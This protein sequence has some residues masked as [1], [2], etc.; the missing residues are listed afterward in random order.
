MK[1]KVFRLLAAVVIASVT[2][3]GV[4]FTSFYYKSI[5]EGMRS[6]LLK[7]AGNMGYTINFARIEALRGETADA[8]SAV[9]ARL[10]KQL[11]TSRGLYPEIRFVYLL[12]MK[13][14]GEIFFYADSEEQ[15]SPA[16]SPPG[17]V[18]G[19]AEQ[20]V[21][22]IFSDG[23]AVVTG[24]T[25]D[26]WGTFMTALIPLYSRYQG[27]IGAVL[28]MD[29]EI[30]EWR[31]IVIMKVLPAVLFFLF[32]FVFSC[33]VFIMIEIK[34][35][36][37]RVIVTA[38]GVFCVVCVVFFAV[39]ND[40][41][42]K[43]MNAEILSELLSAQFRTK[44]A[45]LKQTRDIKLDALKGFFTNSDHVSEKEFRDFVSFIKGGPAVIM[46]FWAE[47]CGK[48]G[49]TVN[50]KAGFS[51]YVSDQKIE[52]AIIRREIV[53][54]IDET[55]RTGLPVI[56]APFETNA[57]IVW[58][59][60]GRNQ[61][62]ILGG[63]I[64]FGLFLSLTDDASDKRIPGRV[65]LFD[66]TDGGR[67]PIGGLKEGEKGI[68]EGGKQSIF[69]KRASEFYS[70]MFFLGRI[71][72]VYIHSE[73]KMP[74]SGALWKTLLAGAAV[75]III[76]AFLNRTLLRNQEL[77]SK[78]E[79][80]AKQLRENEM[81]AFSTLQS[82][83]DGVINLDARGRIRALNKAAFGITGCVSKDTIGKEIREIDFFV[84]DGSDKEFY[85]GFFEGE[86]IYFFTNMRL[87]TA[88]KGQRFIEG[89][90]SPV[91]D[92][93]E[94][95]TGFI[96]AF[97]DITDRV[98]SEKEKELHRER[99]QS[100]VSILSGTQETVQGFLDFALNEAVK[101]TASKMGYIYFYDEVKKEFELNSWSN[102]VMKE[103]E[104]T[105]AH[106]KYHLDKA[107]VWGDAVR[108]RKTIIVNDFEAPDPRKKGYPKGHIHL[109]RFMTIP[110]F[111]GSRIVAVVGVADKE[112]PYDE[113]DVLQLKL[114]MKTV[115]EITCR[116]KAE[117]ELKTSLEKIA[118]I[119]S[120]API[121]MG[122]VVDRVF[123]EVN[124]H[125]GE[126]TGYGREEL[127]GKRARI[128]YPDDE[129]FKKVGEVKYRMMRESG[130]GSVET[131]WKRKDGKVID[132]FL[133]SAWANPED[134]SKGA[135]FTALDITDRAAAEKR[136]R[137]LVE[138][139]QKID[140]MKS[141]FIS[142]VSHELR[143]PLTSIKG[144][145]SLLLRGA[146]GGLNDK[147]MDFLNAVSVNSDRLLKLINDILDISK[148][149]S[150]SFE[151]T[152][153]ACDSS[154]IVGDAVREAAVLADKKSIML[155]DDSVSGVAVYA[156]RF[157]ISQVLVNLITNSI[158]FSPE[159]TAVYI[160]A[161]GVSFDEIKNRVKKAGVAAASG[162]YVMFS[163]KDN[164]RGIDGRNMSRIFERFFQIMEGD[165]KVYKGVGLGLHICKMIVEKH[166]GHIWAES[167]GTGKGA[168]VIF[169][170]PESS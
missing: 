94:R 18:Y 67:V 52:N 136:L 69:N 22:D 131:N 31:K 83:A 13:P 155:V 65:R 112:S 135:V 75:C 162:R 99:L 91:R 113:T 9:Y 149:E 146:A 42:E 170:L 29:V 145:I 159:K 89:S 6:E 71:Y 163:V 134:T 98:E 30:G 133:S 168:E 59:H 1:K 39:Y 63:L 44:T 109:R 123:T 60:E 152:K 49:Y 82:I 125:M 11:I 37:R 62:G 81:Q 80:S 68:F 48:N 102:E 85:T 160:S 150:G 74:Y 148:M 105:E 24:P 151:I 19:E 165:S 27:G 169:I 4:L 154:A 28:G 158:K 58:K 15:G 76:I 141:N 43:R 107:G 161:A 157:R 111:E 72:K 104:V 153:E 33:V 54:A 16:E 2:L 84:L 103:C 147:Q 10:K 70:V 57:C 110:V 17:Q 20:A 77:M 78:V 139:L 66:V 36:G 51:E 124:A 114:L 119:F 46:W 167:E 129:C 23:K 143:T 138:E 115:W 132:V 61:D 130:R 38:A 106:T 34:A 40:E 122:V 47:K 79:Q 127:I 35:R 73:G 64:D 142:M 14:N 164:G 88:H 55:E 50:Y 96:M 41:R 121:G 86:E 53:V 128:I 25:A 90:C 117:Q 21:K 100:L 97:R 56:S 7:V 140:A 3:A 137:Q 32:A 93:D 5:E 118:G 144:F 116:K 8:K 95:L 45:E 108:A 12:G 120:A 156:D 92:D 26:R 166:G 126:M 87:K 101:I